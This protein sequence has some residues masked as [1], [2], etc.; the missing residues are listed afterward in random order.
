MEVVSFERPIAANGTTYGI[1]KVKVSGLGHQVTEI[2]D[3][4]WKFS[5][6]LM[7]YALRKARACYLQVALLLFRFRFWP[8]V[9]LL[10]R[11]E[12]SA[13]SQTVLV[14]HPQSLA[15]LIGDARLFLDGALPVRRHEDGPEV[16]ILLAEPELV[17]LEGVALF[18]GE[19]PAG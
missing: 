18:L 10:F 8:L 2:G 7:M 15:A 19:L 4:T 3:M 6:P 13:R 12:K 16:A 17:G 5:Q 11:N 9:E 14:G 1:Y